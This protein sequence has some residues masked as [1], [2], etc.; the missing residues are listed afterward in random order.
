MVVAVGQDCSR[1]GQ[2]DAGWAWQ[3]RQVFVQRILG[4]RLQL[5]AVAR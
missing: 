3:A 5:V 4:S 2:G 1:G